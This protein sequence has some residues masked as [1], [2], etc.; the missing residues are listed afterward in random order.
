[1]NSF[2][3]LATMNQLAQIKMQLRVVA[4]VL[5]RFVVKGTHLGGADVLIM[6]NVLMMNVTNDIKEIRSWVVH[7]FTIFV[8]CS[9]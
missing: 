2:G 7:I 1:M 9:A 8:L 3:L 5:M 6:Q 4:V